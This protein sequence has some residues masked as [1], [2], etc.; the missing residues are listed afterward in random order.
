MQYIL[1]LQILYLI[2]AAGGGVSHGIHADV[3][4]PLLAPAIRADAFRRSFPLARGDALTRRFAPPLRHSKWSSRPAPSV[5][6]IRREPLDGPLIRKTT[7]DW[8]DWFFPVQVGPDPMPADERQSYIDQWNT[9]ADAWAGASKGATLKGFFGGIGKFMASGI[10][11]TARASA[12]IALKKAE[13]ATQAVENGDDREEAE[14]LAAVWRMAAQSWCAAAEASEAAGRDGWTVARARAIE[15]VAGETADLASAAEIPE[16]ANTWRF[17]EAMWEEAVVELGGAKGLSAEEKRLEALGDL[18]DSVE[19]RQREYEELYTEYEEQKSP[20]QK[21]A[22]KKLAALKAEFDEEDEAERKA[23]EREAAEEQEAELNVAESKE[24][25]IEK[26]DKM[27]SLLEEVDNKQDPESQIFAREKQPK[28]FDEGE[29]VADVGLTSSSGI[30]PV[31][32]LA[33]FVVG[34]GRFRRISGAE[35]PLLRTV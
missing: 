10:T 11:E 12:A 22:D 9:A 24:E 23:A 34:A 13:A 21:E 15:V 16:I 5:C 18:K 4:R 8:Q 3:A 2:G 33:L 6:A 30:I 29:L 1:H 26:A 19:Q 25:V 27:K 35:A 17:A 14:D 20:E 28:K 31:A 32:L 7:W